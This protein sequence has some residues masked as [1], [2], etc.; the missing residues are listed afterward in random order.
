VTARAAQR[1]AWWCM[2]AVAAAAS[3][4]ARDVDMAVEPQLGGAFV[5]PDSAVQVVRVRCLN[6]REALA[7]VLNIEVRNYR[8]MVESVLRNTV[9]LEPGTNLFERHLAMGGYSG[10]VEAELLL[11]D[12]TSLARS[13]VQA[14]G[15]LVRNESLC[16]LSEQPAPFISAGH[17]VPPRDMPGEW[18]GLDPFEVIVAMPESE[19]AL[20]PSQMAALLTWVQSGGALVLLNSGEEDWPLFAAGPADDTGVALR[21]CGAGRIVRCEVPWPLYA[22]DPMVAVNKE[23]IEL[24][25]NMLGRHC[26][27]ARVGLRSWPGSSYEDIG[28][29]RPFIESKSEVR[30]VIAFGVLFASVI[31]L[32]IGPAN[33]L[34]W[35]AVGRA[36]TGWMFVAVIAALGVL[37]CLGAARALR[38]STERQCRFSWCRQPT[39]DGTAFTY[40]VTAA[41]M[42]ARATVSFEFPDTDWMAPLPMT[43]LMKP[44]TAGHAA[45]GW[46]VLDV[47]AAARAP[48]THVRV[49]REQAPG[50]LSFA[51]GISPTTTVLTVVYDGTVPLEHAFI[52]ID[53]RIRHLGTL[54]CA[55]SVTM[56]MS[57]DLSISDDWRRCTGPCILTATGDVARS[58]AEWDDATVRH[59]LV[60]SIPRSTMPLLA[61]GWIASRTCTGLSRSWTLVTAEPEVSMGD[62]A[63]VPALFSVRSGSHLYVRPGESESRCTVRSC[64]PLDPDWRITGCSLRF[65]V[66]EG[67][68]VAAV[69]IFSPSS[70]AWV[71]V[72]QGILDTDAPVSLRPPLDQYFLPGTSMLQVRVVPPEADA[73]SKIHV[74]QSYARLRA[75]R[76]E[77]EVESGD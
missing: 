3:V 56:L 57:G 15:R 35:R 31:A 30:R 50:S 4:A 40:S 9:R 77:V 18:I 55:T 32:L 46:T 73:V 26:R 41:V 60:E 49:A 63:R 68:C 6:R 62:A 53:D 76:I 61:G 39:F 75:P 66:A 65:G 14:T 37:V 51:V 8:G 44:G 47:K 21:R 52:R 19:R 71:N 34:L 69:D 67:H 64:V 1:V 11:Q 20:A 45:N 5:S 43:K 72:Y 28:R 36:R 22:A 27:P 7:A 2:L 13:T 12:G 59:D 54:A 10:A 16:V 29:L 25:S 74:S 48:I 23:R 42:P 70:N 38:G 58:T 17:V 24:F 33:L